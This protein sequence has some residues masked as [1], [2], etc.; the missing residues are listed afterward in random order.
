MASLSN[1]G[2][3]ERVIAAPAPSLCL[4]YANTRFWRGSAAPTESLTDFDALLRWLEQANVVDADTAASLHALHAADPDAAELLFGDA[5]GAREVL[6][7]LFS[8]LA[9]GAESEAEAAQLGA[10]LAAAPFRQQLVLS[11]D[12]AGWR[13]P[14]VAPNVGELLAPVL[15]S[16]ADLALAVSHVRLRSCANEK[17]RWLFL[18]ESKSGTRR[19]CSMSSCGNRAKVHRHFVRNAAQAKG[20]STT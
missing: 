2:P 13:V 20:S 8:A 3:R 4:D 17:C 16:A 18:D 12:M 11:R 19:W 7:R 15:W 6:Y 14:M 1:H 5:L 9:A 10:L